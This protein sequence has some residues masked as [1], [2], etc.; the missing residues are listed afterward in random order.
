MDK[1]AYTGEGVLKKRW[2]VLDNEKTAI[3][4]RN[5][6]YARWTLPYL[7]P[8]NNAT[9]DT[10]LPRTLDAVGGR[11]VNHLANRVVS[12]LFPAYRP[13]LRLEIDPDI[14]KDLRD[15]D[16]V[17]EEE[18][19]GALARG[20]RKAVR[21]LDTLGHRPVAIE[22]AKLLI[23]TG[24]ALMFYP[25]KG[26][27]ILYSLRNYC[28]VR[29]ISGTVIEIITRDVKAFETF[30]PEVQEALKA[31]GRRDKK[32]YKDRTDV[33]LYTHVR[34]QDNGKYTVQQAAD[35]I[36]LDI[37]DNVYAATDLPWVPLVWNRAPGEDYGRGAVED[38]RGAFSCLEILNRALVEGIVAAAE[39]KFLVNP[40]STLDVK[41]LNESRNGTYHSGRE[42]DVTVISTNK[43]M[44]FQ[45]VAEAIDRYERQISQ[46]FLLHS[47]VTRDAERVTAEEIRYQAQE[48]ETAYGGVYSRFKEDWQEPVAVLLLKKDNIKINKSVIYPTVITGLD[49]LSRL[50]DIDNYRMFMDDLALIN[51][52]PEDV[53]PYINKAALIAYLGTNRGI[54][55]S[56][57]VR[58]E[59]EVQAEMAAQQQAQQQ[60]MQ[61]EIGA[62]AMADVGKQMVQEDV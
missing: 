32:D 55:Y 23:I 45:K 7:Y 21:H 1:P 61:S 19:Q 3:H 4:T 57:F 28:V 30:A 36:P 11:A 6:V 8:E 25:E 31:S 10:E 17:P 44:D 14:M 51:A 15:N 20:E 49:S 29:D 60:A 40:G 62:Q 13:F 18:I 43:H 52:V 9:N 58:K 56:Q 16:N 48:L 53:R 41:T 37:N 5:E 38:Y 22:A 47:G 42:G 27:C 59:E 39:I 12:T 54:D 26:K 50:G 24:N 35:C 33:E 46:G 34:L 2:S